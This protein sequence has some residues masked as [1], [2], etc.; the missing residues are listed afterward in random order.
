MYVFHYY[1]VAPL[2]ILG[3]RTESYHVSTDEEVSR[4][5]AQSS[6]VRQS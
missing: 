5:V 2:R 6:T 4:H 3:F 1:D